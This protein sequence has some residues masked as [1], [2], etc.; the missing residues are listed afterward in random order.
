MK[1]A[2]KVP[3]KTPKTTN[4]PNDLT[5]LKSTRLFFLWVKTETAEVRI[6]IENAVPTDKCIK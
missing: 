1:D 6:V 2:K 3:I 4:Y 5:I